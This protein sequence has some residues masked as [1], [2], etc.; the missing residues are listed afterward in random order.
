MKTLIQGIMQ[1]TGLT[2]A[3]VNSIADKAQTT[4]KRYLIPKKAGG[5]RVIFHPSRE[6]KLLQYSC[7][8]L[9]FDSFVPS[10]SAFGY[11]RGKK[12]PLRMNAL[13]H[14][15]NPFLLRLDFKDF[16]PSIRPGDLFKFL[17]VGALINDIKVSAEDHRFLEKV[18]FLQNDDGSLGLPIGAPSSPWV[19]NLIMQDLD[20]K[21]T[22]LANKKDFIYTRYADD[23]IFS[24][25]TKL[26][27]KKLLP[28]IK[29][30]LAKTT[31]PSLALNDEKTC[32]MSRNCRRAVTGLIITPEG[33]VTIGRKKKRLVRS[34][35]HQMRDNTISDKDRSFLQGYLAF[36]HDV[37]PDYFNN[38]S[39]KYSAKLLADA[40][41][42]PN[43][44]TPESTPPRKARSPAPSPTNKRHD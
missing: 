35:L 22:D 15:Q 1:F 18:F 5:K 33:N 12:S 42:Q 30:I 3:E 25:S 26:A 9:M 32:Y 27:A 8:E 4:Y 10:Q 2:S 28:N 13:A 11:I 24:T 31:H 43:K 29:K 40:L 34:L 14:A 17:Q 23:L 37:E 41:K 6:T 20:I 39:L 19:S 16:F 7:I 36:M 21:L 44:I 38:L